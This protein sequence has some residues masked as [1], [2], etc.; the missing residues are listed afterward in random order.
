MHVELVVPKRGNAGGISLLACMH[1]RKSEENF[2]TCHGLLMLFAAAP[3]MAAPATKT[4]FTAKVRFAPGNIK[5]GEEWVTMDG[6]YYVKG[7]VSEGNV[8]GDILGTLLIVCHATLD[9]NMHACS[10][11]IML[12]NLFRIEYI[13]WIKS[14]LYP[15]HKLYVCFVSHF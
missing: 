10:P 8:T 1:V 12:E 14:L 6:I 7:Q 3:V 15:F 2:T 4:L 5:P 13:F 11:K 9:L